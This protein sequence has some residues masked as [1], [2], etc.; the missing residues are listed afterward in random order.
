MNHSQILLTFDYS[1][2]SISIA[3]ASMVINIDGFQ[4][5]PGP[6]YPRRIA[7]VGPQAYGELHVAMPHIPSSN[8]ACHTFRCQTQLHGLQPGSDGL[9]LTAAVAIVNSTLKQ[10]WRWNL[11]ITP[12]P[13]AGEQVFTVFGKGTERLGLC[14]A[15]LTPPA[16]VRLVYV[17][18][19]RCGCPPFSRLPDL[20]LPRT[21]LGKARAYALW[22]QRDH[23]AR[24]YLGRWFISYYQ[25]HFFYS[26]QDHHGQV[27]YWT[28]LQD[29]HKNKEWTIIEWKLTRTE[30]NRTLFTDSYIRLNIVVTL[31][32]KDLQTKKPTKQ[33]NKW[34]SI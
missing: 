18:L 28:T 3:M 33:T 21:T 12:Q 34:I 31:L 17:D 29:Q 6:F 30:N 15:W 7:Y 14:K 32:I 16:G 4:H 23:N 10:L 8:A 5:G 9:P 13:T 2:R 27:N 25:E 19:D 20:G 11:Y 22:L 24:A 1:I 26:S